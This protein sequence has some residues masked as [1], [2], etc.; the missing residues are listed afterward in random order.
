MEHRQIID[1]IEEI[2]DDVRTGILTTIDQEEE[3]SSK[4]MVPVVLKYPTTAIYCFSQRRCE[5]HS[6]IASNSKVEWM[7]QTED[8]REIVKIQGTAVVNDNPDIKAEML[9]R[10]GDDIKTF[11][12][13]DTI[14]EEPVVI[15]TSIET[16]E[17]YKP[18]DGIVEK[19]IFSQIQQPAV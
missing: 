1:K 5:K 2:I 13:A 3:T 16:A 19:V 9:D 4:W 10:L 18:T 12:K 15:E 7:I 14:V 17:Y 6:H 8:Y 11:F